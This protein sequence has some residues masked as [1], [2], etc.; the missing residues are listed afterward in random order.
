M[1]PRT[2]IEDYKMSKVVAI[3]RHFGRE[4][5]CTE[6]KKLA[7]MREGVRTGLFVYRGLRDGVPVFETSKSGEK[8]IVEDYRER[9]GVTD[10]GHRKKLN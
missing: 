5:E 8:F 9:K 1:V 10:G 2:D 4:V 7:T 3:L 6:E